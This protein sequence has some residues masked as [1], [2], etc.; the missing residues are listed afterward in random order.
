MEALAT[1]HLLDSATVLC[2]TTTGLD[3]AVLGRRAFDLAVIDEAGQGTEP[4]AWLPLLRCRRVVLAGDHCQLPPTV[5]SPQAAAEGLGRSLLERLADLYG[6]TV[7]RRLGVQYR[8]H[9]AIMAFL[10][11]EFYDGALVADPSVAAHRLADLPGVT[12]DAR[13]AAPFQFLDTAG[14]GHDEAAEPDGESRFNP[15]EAALVVREVRRLL[16]AGVRP[17]DVAVITPYAAQV[18]HLRGRLE[19]PGLEID[20]IDG[21][22]GREKEAV[23][24]SLVRS[25]LEGEIGFLADVR[26]LNVALTRAR[27]RLLVIGDSATLA[28]HPFYRRFLDHAEAAG[29]YGTVW[30]D[31]LEE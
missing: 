26:R 2:A 5:V 17:E 19:V 28:H 21:F 6:A 11:A 9:A 15:G 20:S 4:G 3:D 14:A 29:A 7:L 31:P 27:R 13:L 24:L 12:A 25:N 16:A 22:Q 18:R 8:M 30:E 23:V 1:D 10:S